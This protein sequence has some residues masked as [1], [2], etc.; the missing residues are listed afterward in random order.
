MRQITSVLLV[1]AMLM[2]ASLATA[3]N[4]VKSVE[5]V[6]EVY[7]DG[8]KVSF[9]VL[10][11][12]EAINASSVGNASF[13]VEGK[14]VSR[15]YANDKPERTQT[16]KSG[17]YVII[18]LKNTVSLT[19]DFGPDAKKDDKVNT[20][21]PK[22]GDGGSP[23]GGIVA[24]NKPT[25]ETNP[26]PGD[27]TVK[28]LTAIKTLKGKSILDS[29]SIKN[30]SHET[31]IADEFKQL[32]YNDPKT[33]VALRY[34]LFI[35][36]DYTTSR[37]YPVVL[38]M[39]DAS[40]ANQEDD[41]TLLQGNGA[42]VW[43]SPEEQAKHP[44]IVVAPQ[45]DEI[46]VDDNFKATSSAEA[47]I[48][49]LEYLKTQ[50][51]IDSDRIYTTGQSMGCMLSYLLM[52]THPDEFA[53]AYLVA[54]QWDSTVIAPMAK[55]PLWLVTATGDTKSTA[56][57]ETA[58]KLWSSLGAKT[59]S[60]KWPL[61]STAD[62]RAKEIDSLR[63]T[64]ATIRYSQLQGGW[65]N[66]TWRVAYTFEGIRDWLFEQSK[67]DSRTIKKNDHQVD[68]T[69]NNDV[70]SNY[71]TEFLR[72]ELF[73]KKD[74]SV[75]IVS[76]RGDWHGTAENSLH[77]IQK[78]IE[79]GCK[80]VMVDVRKTSD[81][82][83]V[84]M[85]DE[86]VDRMT[87]GT[88]AVADKTLAEI[89]ALRLKE[90]HGNM[91]PLQVP[92]IE[93]ALKFCKGKIL[94]TVSNYKDYKKDIDA[95]VKSTGASTEFFTI[96]NL[97]RKVAETWKMDIENQQDSH[98]GMKST[99]KKL[100]SSGVTVFVT[101]APKAFNSMLGISHVIAS[102]TVSKVYGDGQKIAYIVVRYD[103]PID[104]ST[105]SAS[106][107]KVNG[108]E[109]ADAFTSS[110]ETPEGKAPNGHSVIIMLRNSLHLDATGTAQ[111][112][113]GTKAQTLDQQQHAI[114]QITAGSRP[115]KKANSYPTTV[116]FRQVSPI[117][118]TK[119]KT[120]TEK[121][122]LRNTMAK[123]LVVDDFKQ[124][125]FHDSSTGDTLRYN[126]F[127]PTNSVE[128]EK[129]PLVIFLHDASCS[130]QEDTYTLRQGLGAVV[131]ASPEE[132]AKH[133]SFVL[134]PQYDEVVVDDNY[135]KT[136]SVT[137]TADLINDVIARYPIDTTRIYITG[138]SMGCMMTY[139]LMS[140]YP[141]LFTAGYLVA[142]HWRA[143]DLAPMAK[144]PLWLVSSA[145]KSKTGAEE[146]IA[147]W[148]RNGGMAESAEWQ[149]VASPSER[150]AETAAL[151]QK[152]GNIHYSHLTT[153]SHFDT[154][155]VAYSFEA[156]RDWLFNQR[157]Q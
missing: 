135:N 70:E 120:Y 62:V 118:T 108:H 36:K 101:D 96:D 43:A 61:D 18:E 145:G 82:Q 4:S 45:Y 113:A 32:V 78:A 68:F 124:N 20:E 100:L 74:T 66:G 97:P 130:G 9:V 153:G 52:S 104:G 23:A 142:G 156:V 127:V 109:V 94:I 15:I 55:K 93:E 85:A 57:A 132:Q 102:Q 19:P 150:D 71:N 31:L 115:E 73:D 51:N 152:G 21:K 126:L 48:N 12:G 49:L 7:G 110:D 114:P 1:V 134:A 59:A 137:T 35:P 154:W 26:F 5:S 116:T 65:H 10:Q 89:K 63:H 103:Q 146:A 81:G 39:H 105:V 37:K 38:F 123:T 136:A 92:T 3:A 69:V 125:V 47:T 64:P 53:A 119:G 139:L 143:S 122:L 46:V 129:Y 42:T 95:L 131:W 117:K 6:S 148:Q 128:Q 80:A 67:K 99:Y 157:K 33:G 2:M 88:G 141:S 151:L 84:L 98:D 16:G 76:H 87:N 17:N 8:A 91:T 121:L 144:K 30:T 83:L 133:P 112:K 54:G 72:R 75:F 138:Q 44:S 77:S 50:Y 56:G 90:Y 41:Y 155:R 140:T 28:Q 107:Y 111:A 79:K 25:R 13:E 106:T 27:V 24:G 14:T 86:T 147:E 34:N 149:L 40:G 29:D 58:L 11:Y 22:D 60:A